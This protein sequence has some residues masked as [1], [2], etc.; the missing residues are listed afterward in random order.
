MNSNYALECAIQLI[1]DCILGFDNYTDFY[2]ETE[3]SLIIKKLKEIKA[4]E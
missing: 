3:L 4:N 1:E 2:N